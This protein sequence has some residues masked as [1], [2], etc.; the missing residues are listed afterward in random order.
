[1]QQFDGSILSFFPRYAD[2]DIKTA[3]DLLNLE[4]DWEELAFVCNGRHIFDQRTLQN[5]F[6]PEVFAELIPPHP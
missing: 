1:M 4:A 5:C 2:F 6:L 3:V